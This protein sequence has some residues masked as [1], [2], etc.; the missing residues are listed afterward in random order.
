MHCIGSREGRELREVWNK[1]KGEAV[2]SAE[3]LGREVEEVF[4]TGVEG[5]GGGSVLPCLSGY[6][7][8]DFPCKME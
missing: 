7:G 6:V 2:E 4:L 3:W 1:L 5:V 8:R